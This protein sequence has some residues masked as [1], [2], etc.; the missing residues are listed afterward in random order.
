[1]KKEQVGFFYG[2]NHEGLK[3][4]NRTPTTLLPNGFVL[5]QVGRGMCC[6]VKIEMLSSNKCKN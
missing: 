6:T 1:M 3:T 2:A 4:L 5:G